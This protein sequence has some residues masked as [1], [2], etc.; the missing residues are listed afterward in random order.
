MR[1]L[2][3]FSGI[4]GFALAA[5][6]AGIETVGFCEIEEFPR[7]VLEKNF[8]GVPIHHDIR[9]LNGEEYE[10]IDIIT[11]G[12]PCQPF[13]EAGNKRGQ[14]DDRHLWPEVF[15]IVKQARPTWVV[16]E[17]VAGH[18]TLGLDDVLFDL[19]GEGYATRALIIPACAADARHK[20]NRVWI[21]ANAT[22]DRD[23]GGHRDISKADEGEQAQ[24]ESRENEAWKCINGGASP[25]NVSSIKAGQARGADE[26]Q[27]EPRIQ[28][29][30]DGIP[31]RVDRVKSLGNAI[32]PQVAYEILTAIKSC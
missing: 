17:N 24:E 30:V 6:W 4:G 18:I 1:H 22:S 2:D 16:C 23:L 10:G 3:L 14:K 11:G 27:A 32:V 19:E 20:R 15:R 9:E 12:Y 13:S 31:D 28:R 25:R 7:K 21:I 29:V 26:W 5:R 8:P